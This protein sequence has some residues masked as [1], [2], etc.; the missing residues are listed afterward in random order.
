MPTSDISSGVWLG[1]AVTALLF[2]LLIMGLLFIAVGR[3]GA[4]QALLRSG[5]SSDS[6]AKSEAES[7][8]GKKSRPDGV[9]E[10]FLRENPELQGLRKSEQFSAYRRWRKEQGLNWES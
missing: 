8:S 2:L 7:R 5:A 6:T 3:L 4:I 9:F 1:L 10:R